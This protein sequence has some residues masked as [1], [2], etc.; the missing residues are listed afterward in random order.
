MTRLLRCLT[1]AAMLLPAA[2]ARAEDVTVMISGGFK[3]TYQALLPGFEAA[4]G[5]RVA[6]LP[7]P[8]MGTTRDAIPQRLA[9]GEPDDVL[10]MVGSALD[11]LIAD[12]KAVPGSKVDL[13]LSPIGMAV[14]AG[15]PVPD[16][17]TVDKLRAALLAARSVAYSDIA[18]GV[19]IRDEL[20]GRLGIAAE[21]AG[22]ARMIPATPVAEI[23]ARGEADLGFQQVAELLPVPGI[24]FAGR[25][26]AAV[27]RNTVFSAG[28]STAARHPAAGR[29]LIAYMASPAAGPVMA[30]MGLDPAKP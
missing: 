24:A 18:S 7:G 9:R 3:S 23:V 26:P 28:L 2:G 15:A 5:D 11:A 12:G 1:L 19:Y 8:S 21:M 22:K 6:T 27:Q 30:R 16:I 25:L 13:A 17:G 10:I 29:A 20:F 4:S 14:K